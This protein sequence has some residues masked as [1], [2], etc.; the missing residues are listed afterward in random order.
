MSVWNFRLAL[1]GDG[2]AERCGDLLGVSGVGVR[3]VRKIGRL[4]GGNLGVEIGEILIVLKP[5]NTTDFY[6]VFVY[7]KR[8]IRKSKTQ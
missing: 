5:S 2:C 1:G 8:K 6:A 3:M 7:V 4:S